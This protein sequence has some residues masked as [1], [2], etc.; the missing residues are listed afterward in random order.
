LWGY[1]CDVDADGW[2]VDPRHPSNR[3]RQAKPSQAKP[4]Q[5]KPSQAKPSQAK[6]S[7][8]NRGTREPGGQDKRRP[9][10]VG[11]GGPSKNNEAR[12]P[13]TAAALF[14]ERPR[15]RGRAIWRV[16]PHLVTRCE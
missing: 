9:S 3:L 1:R 14:R 12:A 7:V 11:P 10:F 6:P 8:M 13:S 2:P 4:S 5:A 16:R 15:V